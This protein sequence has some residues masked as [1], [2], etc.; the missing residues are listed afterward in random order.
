MHALERNERIE[1]FKIEEEQP[2][3]VSDEDVSHHFM[4]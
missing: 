3:L 4:D 2:N 1:S